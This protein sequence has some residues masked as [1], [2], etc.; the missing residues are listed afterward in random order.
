M[1]SLSYAQ[2]GS[3]VSTR[4]VALLRIIGLATVCGV[5]WGLIVSPKARQ[6]VAHEL[7][8]ERTHERITAE[9]NA[10]AGSPD[11]IEQL[12]TMSV[13]ANA[14]A[15]FGVRPN[16]AQTLYNSYRHLA[17]ECAVR[18][19]RVEPRALDSGAKHSTVRSVVYTVDV[20]GTYEGVSRMIHA[21][22]TKMGPTRVRAFRMTPAAKPGAES[23]SSHDWL[24]ATIETV[25]VELA[26]PDAVAAAAKRVSQSP[27]SDGGTP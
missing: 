24:V 27:G 26:M 14:L 9:L 7:A 8:I 20:A 18:V 2:Q 25:H 15:E 1:S 6:A 3:R 19:D 11:P 4:H 5:A 13:A 23:T 21:I 16:D 10:T 22:Q 17:E 12:A